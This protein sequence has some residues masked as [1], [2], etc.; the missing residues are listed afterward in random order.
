MKKLNIK[1]LIAIMVVMLLIGCWSST[2]LAADII[3]DAEFYILKGQNGEKWGAEDKALDAKLA[4]LK[5]RHGRPPNIVYIL[6][7]DMTFGAVGF[8]ALQKNFGFTTPNI[9]RMAAEGIN[10]RHR[11]SRGDCQDSRAPGLAHACTTSVPGSHRRLLPDSL[12]SL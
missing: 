4:E 9:N 3:H 11:R 10:R 12:L 6:W 2:G 1:H 7:D 8:P 5:K